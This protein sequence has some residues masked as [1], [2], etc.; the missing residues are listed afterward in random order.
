MGTDVTHVLEVSGDTL[1]VK[2]VSVENKG[3][4]V[5]SVRTGGDSVSVNPTMWDRT[6]RGVLQAST[7]ILTAVHVIVTFMARWD[8][9]VIRRQASVIV[10]T[11]SKD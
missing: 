7:N 10:G 8:S 5:T 11:I 1:T 3:Q 4:S 6:V 2:H 9:H